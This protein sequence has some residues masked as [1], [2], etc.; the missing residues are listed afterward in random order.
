MFSVTPDAILFGVCVFECAAILLT[1]SVGTGV[2]IV[3]ALLVAARPCG[4]GQVERTALGGRS[5]S[6]NQS[7]QRFQEPAQL[8][9]VAERVV[10]EPIALAK[11]THPIGKCL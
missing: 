6:H 8:A 3:G 5:Q 4:A 10:G 1:R 9:L 2:A 7:Q 11:R